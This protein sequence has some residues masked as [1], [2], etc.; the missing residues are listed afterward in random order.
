MSRFNMSGAARQAG[1][2]LAALLLAG[3]VVPAVAAD[4]PGTSWSLGGE[5]TIKLS[6][7]GQSDQE[8]GY[9]YAELEFDPAAT[10]QAGD[11]VFTNYG[12]AAVLDMPCTFTAT[13][14]KKAT[15]KT[16]FV[17]LLEDEPLRAELEAELRDELG[18]PGIA[19][20][21]ASKPAKGKVDPSGIMDLKVTW[22]GN[23]YVPSYGLNIKLSIASDL[24]GGQYRLLAASVETPRGAGD[25]GE[26]VLSILKRLLE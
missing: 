26:R 22:K 9:E 12:M 3:W 1:V 16:K 24:S 20:S 4:L 8:T 18:D 11:C 6:A 10:P 7:K 2:A 17:L 14:P 13:L 21:L 19:V 23:I 5:T 25:L 15:G